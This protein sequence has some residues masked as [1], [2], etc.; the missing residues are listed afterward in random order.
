VHATGA[1]ISDAQIAL[2]R[3]KA[4]EAGLDARF[5]AVVLSVSG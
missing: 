5:A 3:R 4:A 2:A 1:D